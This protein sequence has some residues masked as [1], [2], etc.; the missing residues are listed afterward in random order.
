MRCI[1][2]NEPGLAKE[3]EYVVCPCCNGTG[4]DMDEGGECM[5][6]NGESKVPLEMTYVYTDAE[7]LPASD[8]APSNWSQGT[9]TGFDRGTL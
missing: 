1:V 7:P 3:I 6:C 9:K 4:T 8:E 2:C 5:L